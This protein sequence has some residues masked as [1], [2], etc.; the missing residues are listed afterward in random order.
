MKSFFCFLLLFSLSLSSLS[1]EE[2]ASW[3]NEDIL[4]GSENDVVEISASIAN[5]YIQTTHS[6]IGAKA[7]MSLQ[8]LVKVDTLTVSKVT[9]T[10]TGKK[11]RLIQRLL[12]PQVALGEYLKFHTSISNELRSTIL[13]STTKAIKS[14]GFIATAGAIAFQIAMAQNE[15]EIASTILSTVVS[16]VLIILAEYAIELAIPVEG[17]PLYIASVTANI[18][19]DLII[20]MIVDLI[21]KAIVNEVAY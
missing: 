1:G 17:V 14:L 7:V 11:I 2:K 16:T 12:L 15:V 5:S 4:G 8:D 18:V 9:Y 3:S 20:T 21:I 19:S 10:S 13:S 6:K